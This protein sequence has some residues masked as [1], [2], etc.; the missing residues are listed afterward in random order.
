MKFEYSAGAFIYRYLEGKRLFLFMIKEN[1]EYDLAKGHIE[2]GE[3]ARTAALREVKEETGIEVKLLPY[4]SVRTKY[5]FRAGKE[6]IV[7][8]VRFFISMVE[9]ADVSISHEHKGY[10][11]LDYESAMRKIKFKD[12]RSVLDKVNEYINKHEE[13]AEL[14]YRYAML[15]KETTGWE[16]SVKLVEG[17]GPLNAKVM[18]LGQAPGRF[19]DERGR[20]F[21]GRSGMLLDKEM[22]R[23]GIRRGSVYITSVVQF[24]P[25]KNRMPTDME[26]EAC[27]PFLLGQM[28]IVKPQ[29]V[30]LLG[31]LASYTMLGED[32]VEKNHGRIIR[33]DGVTY[34]VT[35]HPAAALRFKEKEALMREDFSSFRKEI[36]SGSAIEIKS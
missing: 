22:R 11:W 2:K 19:E 18:F 17:E 5:F 16:L 9:G 8:Q 21:V 23:A 13:M 3:N 7:K 29:F 32:E 33:K 26:I 12:L 34:M 24:F 31:N 27:R 6:K 1:G 14:N 35:F 15:P 30:I 25:P 4:F 10:E 28:K 36:S 20:P